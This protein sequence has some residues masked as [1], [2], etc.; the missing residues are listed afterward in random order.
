[1]TSII[2]VKIFNILDRLG[3]ST[4]EFLNDADPADLKYYKPEN[5]EFK[6]KACEVYND[7]FK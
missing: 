4:P 3:I 1:M 2:N 7:N 5:I 6:K